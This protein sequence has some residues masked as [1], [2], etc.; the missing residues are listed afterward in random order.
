MKILIVEDN[1]D[2]SW[3]WK[4]ELQKN[5][6]Y[7][8]KIAEDGEE[9]MKLA[10]SF[11][12]DIIFLDLVLPKKDGMTVLAELKADPALKHIAVVISSNLD[13]DEKIKQALSLGAIDYFVKTQHFIYEVIEKV[14]KYIKP[15]A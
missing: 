9:A 10:K 15:A 8:I 13:G 11:M 12:P 3:I 6:E 1:K 14:Q 7:V 4:E 5:K 2:L